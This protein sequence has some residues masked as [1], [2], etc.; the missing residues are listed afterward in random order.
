MNFVAITLESLHAWR[1]KMLEIACRRGAAAGLVIGSIA[2]GDS[3]PSSD[4]D[5]LV[6]FEPGRSLFDEVHLID[7]LGA[8][9]GTRV[10]VVARG[11]LLER[12]QHIVAEA[13]PL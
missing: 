3:T 8:V 6:E 2:R 11:R 10:D 7:E 5:S 1:D 4:I 13:V 9:L 12:D